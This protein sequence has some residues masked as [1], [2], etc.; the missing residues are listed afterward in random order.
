MATKLKKLILYV[1]IILIGIWFSLGK[2]YTH[3][4]GYTIAV[5]ADTTFEETAHKFKNV[6]EV[7][8]FEDE[9]QI[10]YEL[11]NS[12]VDAVITDRLSGLAG[13]KEGGYNNIKM[14]GDLLYEEIIAVAFNREDKALRQTINKALT[15]II[16]DGTYVKISQKYFGCNILEGMKR[17]I[18]YPNEP[19]ATDSSWERIKLTGEIYF[20]M[21]GGYPPF[22]YY[23]EQ[24]EL[25][26]FDVEIAKTVCDRLG[27]KF[28]PVTTDWDGIIDGLLNK[29]YNGIWGS[30]KITDER[31]KLMDFSDPY[32]LSGAQLFVRKD[33]PIIGTKNLETI[34]L[35]PL[36]N[37]FDFNKMFEPFF[38]N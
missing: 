2:Q 38:N 28:V 3:I 12:R 17:D 26:G 6:K 5:V 11:A 23:D 7:V 4:S 36:L 31:L 24:N 19:T 27:I 22:N 35:R 29:Q 30:M 32:Y 8:P 18:T 33:S 13:I 16:D 10:L 9:D 14:M 34:L 21:S 1:V 37:S 20:A 15:E 25:T